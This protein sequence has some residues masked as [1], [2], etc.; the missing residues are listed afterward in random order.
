MT[1][2]VAVHTNGTDTVIAKA[3]G[4]RLDI[5]CGGN[6]QPGFVGMDIRPLPGVD[7]VHDINVHPW[8]IPDET[9]LVAMASHLVEHIPP[10]AFI[11]GK[12]HMLFIEFMDEVWRILKPGGEFAIAL[13]H[14][15]SQ[16]YLQDPTHCNACNE[17]T[18]AYFD[19]DNGSGLWNIYQPKPWR[20]KFLNWSPA[21]N[22]EVIM[23]KR[24]L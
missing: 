7:I 15:D 1:E 5:G 4:I 19:P 18:W 6:K 2:T 9:V 16:G 23:V 21:A 17:N 10:M 11:D 24:A 12:T 22:I 3:L 20:I 8:P 14:G 13:P